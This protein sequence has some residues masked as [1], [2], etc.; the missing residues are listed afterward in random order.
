MGADTTASTGT[1]LGKPG[2][3]V[4]L[5]SQC[6]LNGY[7]VNE[8]LEPEEAGCMNAFLLLRLKTAP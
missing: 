2:C 5:L 4:P 6:L 8:L 1:V 7:K 3:V